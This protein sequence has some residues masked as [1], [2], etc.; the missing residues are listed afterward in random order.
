MK[1]KPMSFLGRLAVM[2]FILAGCASHPPD[3]RVVYSNA[4][5]NAHPARMWLD[6]GSY[7]T[8]LFPKGARRLGLNAPEISKPTPISLDG[9]TLT[10]PLPVFRLPLSV[11]LMAIMP[12][13]SLPDG[14]VGW[15]DI[16]DNILVFDADRRM[17]RSVLQLPPAT[18]G[19]LKLRVVPSDWLFLEIPMPDGKIGTAEVDTGSDLGL[20]MSPAQMK[21]WRAAHR[22]SILPSGLGYVGSFG[23]YISHAGWADEFT[24][25]PLK[26]TDVVVHDMPATQAAAIQGIEPGSHAA[27]SIGMWALNRMDLVVDAKMGLPTSTPDLR[28][29]RLTPG[30]NIWLAGTA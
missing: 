19:W 26:L 28:R 12:R 10:A 5:V 20:E 3:T 7:S 11:R 18:A 22:N 17:V 30:L 27:W 9:Q 23:V 4:S 15:P 21:E 25:G 13:S 6:T 29:D 2:A 1:F 16:R 24:L 8:G 14:V